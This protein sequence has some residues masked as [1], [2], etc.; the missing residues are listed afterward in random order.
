MNKINIINNNNKF[1]NF[2]ILPGLN[3]NNL[4]NMNNINNQN[5]EMNNMPEIQSI[6]SQLSNKIFKYKDKSKYNENDNAE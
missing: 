6:Q 4:N 1:L 5:N 3:M 2:N